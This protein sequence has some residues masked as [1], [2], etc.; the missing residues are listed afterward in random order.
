MINCLGRQFILWGAL[1][2]TPTSRER[3]ETWSQGRAGISMSTSFS[4]S[5]FHRFEARNK[6]VLIQQGG[7]IS[8]LIKSISQKIK[9]SLMFSTLRSKRWW[10]LQEHTQGHDDEDV[11]WILMSSR[12]PNLTNFNSHYFDGITTYEQKSFKGS[13]LMGSLVNRW[14]RSHLKCLDS[15]LI[16]EWLTD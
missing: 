1:A 9:P 10:V 7:I 4:L 5:L 14:P 15:S 8:I 6:K 3:A 11:P 12:V 2:V 13:L 16:A